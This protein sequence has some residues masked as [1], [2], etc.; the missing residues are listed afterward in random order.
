[1]TRGEL[2]QH[3]RRVESALERAA[4]RMHEAVEWRTPLDELMLSEAAERMGDV[5]SEDEMALLVEFFRRVFDFIFEEGAHPGWVLRRVY[6]LAR[7]Y[8]PDLI[9]HMNGTDL[10]LLFGETRAAQSYRMQLIFDRLRMSGVRGF[11][12]GGCKSEESR[13]TYAASAAGN[14]NRSK[15]KSWRE[16]S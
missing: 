16:K 5:H 6:A 10:G 4:A 2:T 13:A 8:R 3:E 12:G 11:R 15:K 14:H 9:L 7:R 1:M